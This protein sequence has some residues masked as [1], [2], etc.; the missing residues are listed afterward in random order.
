M[1][2]IRSPKDLFIGD[3]VKEAIR[4]KLELLFFG[5]QGGWPPL[6]VKKL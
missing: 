3:K 2:S 6:R 4:K 1:V 5:L